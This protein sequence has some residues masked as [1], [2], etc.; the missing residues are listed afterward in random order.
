MKRL[1]ACLSFDVQTVTLFSSVWEIAPSHPS[2]TTVSVNLHMC[3]QMIYEMAAASALASDL[4]PGVYDKV[5]G[6]GPR[7]RK[8]KKTSSL[9]GVQLWWSELGHLKNRHQ[10]QTCLQESFRKLLS[11]SAMRVEFVPT[12][13]QT[14]VHFC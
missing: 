2:F 8:V 7:P 14:L 13:Y 5:Q 1:C 9:G 10:Q 6:L 11:T 4:D 3:R 12:R